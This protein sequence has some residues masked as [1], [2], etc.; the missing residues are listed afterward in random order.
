M[1]PDQP[2]D[3]HG[4]YSGSA[5]VEDG[6]MYLFYTGNV[7]QLGDYNYITNGRESNTILAVS[8]DGEQMES[9]ELLMTIKIIRGI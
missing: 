8:S 4:A 7:K 3:C 6:K 1:Q 9:K 2:Y 5:L